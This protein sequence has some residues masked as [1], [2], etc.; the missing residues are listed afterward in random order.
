MNW[1]HLK[2]ALLA[3]EGAFEEAIAMLDSMK[4]QG[5]DYPGAREFRN[6]LRQMIALSAPGPATPES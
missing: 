5:V 1:F 6:Q 4:A 3:K 2:S